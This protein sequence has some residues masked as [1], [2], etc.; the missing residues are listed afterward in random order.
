MKKII[1]LLFCFFLVFCFSIPVVNLSQVP[2]EKLTA[3]YTIN[4]N[5]NDNFKTIASQEGWNG[6]GTFLSPIILSSLSTND[7]TNFEINNTNL[8]FVIQDNSFNLYNH[9]I[10]LMF[11]NISNGI[12]KNNV[13]T[14]TSQYIP[15]IIIMNNCSNMVLEGNNLL[16]NSSSNLDIFQFQHSNNISLLNNN[17][18]GM[19]RNL[20]V[21]SFESTNNS[22][23]KNNIMT[24][25]GIIIENSKY[26]VVNNNSI[27]SYNTA[28]LMRAS[29]HI[30]IEFNNISNS[31][32]ALMISLGSSNDII[33]NNVIDNI[34]EGIDFFSG[35]NNNNIISNNKINDFSLGFESFNLAF[36]KN[37]TI[38]N[39]LVTGKKSNAVKLDGGIVIYNGF[40]CLIANNTV[41]KQAFGIYVGNLSN[42]I[43]NN[44]IISKNTLYY[45]IDAKGYNLSITNNVID[46]NYEGIDLETHNSIIEGNRVFDNY[47]N[48]TNIYSTSFSDKILNN[49]IFGNKEKG[50][51]NQGFNNSIYNNTIYNNGTTIFDTIIKYYGYEALFIGIIAVVGIMVYRKRR[52][53]P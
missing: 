50:I 14:S 36:E 16:F 39:N 32:T 7:L 51:F 44:N 29:N 25:C 26:N 42:S 15:T 47:H 48:G 53:V 33:S 17:L 5:G 3:G 45:G 30:N 46:H 21:I 22:L 38:I 13:F 6:L 4:I 12:I 23:I 41:T 35:I 31:Y 37:I 34:S 18:V 1:S 49:T 52:K 43:I 9:N 10:S 20:I 28:F 11:T 24:N 8:Y 2:K 27:Q 19:I 40:G